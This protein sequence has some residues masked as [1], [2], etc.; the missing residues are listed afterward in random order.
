MTDSPAV[1]AWLASLAADQRAA[2]DALRAAVAAADPNL[3]ESIKWNAPSFALD[4]DDRATLNLGPKGSLR[5]VLHRG[6]RATAPAGFGVADPAGLA[7][8]PTPDRGIVAFRDHADVEA[9]AAAVTDLVRRW[10]A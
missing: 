5:L 7:K 4:G 8:W 3:V 10:L 2:V 9:K 6:A 1:S